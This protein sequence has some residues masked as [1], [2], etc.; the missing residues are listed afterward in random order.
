MNFRRVFLLTVCVLASLCAVW[1]QVTGQ[2]GQ[3]TQS[4]DQKK[5]EDDRQDVISLE[6]NL[7]VVNVTV[8][9]LADKYVRG[10]R[11]EHFRLSEDKQ[12][13]KILSISFE[14]SPFAAAILLD[15]SG[16][17]EYKMTLARAACTS[18]VDGIREGDQFAIYSFA[19]TQ[20]KQRQPFGEVKDVGDFV[21]DL[22]PDGMTPLYDALVKASEDLLAREEKRRAI[23][24]VSDGGDS[25][26]RA[27]LD[28]AIRK[29]AEANV[30]IYCVDLSD[31]GVFRTTPR[32]NGAE[33]MKTLAAKT[34]GRF[35]STPGGRDLKDA[36]VQTVEE[37]RNQYT[38]TYEPSNEKRDGKW[39]AI[40]VQLTKPELK[41]RSRQ[42]YYAPKEKK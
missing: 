28:Q 42:G 8:T 16:S 20:V 12:A 9:D 2:V 1:A 27:S 11:R 40:D 30:T 13:Q 36:F 3:A 22:R 26:S 29:A 37:L 34:G 23:L 19:G 33:I 10:L 4:Q 31:R 5:Q 6:T 39:R 14:E 35:F 21:W 18:F 38:L 32:D 25:T 17:M 15:C 41:A 24:L 7:V